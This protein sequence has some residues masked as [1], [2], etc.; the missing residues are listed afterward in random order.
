[1]RCDGAAP[2]WRLPERDSVSA[3]DGWPFPTWMD[4]DG[5]RRRMSDPEWGLTFKLVTDLDTFMRGYLHG[6]DEMPRFPLFRCI[7]S[8]VTF[9]MAMGSAAAANRHGKGYA[10]AI[11]AGS[12]LQIYQAVIRLIAH[13][14]TLRNFRSFPGPPMPKG[15]A[16]PL[17]SDKGARLLFGANAGT[18]TPPK[19]PKLING[20][21][22]ICT[23]AHYFL[24]LHEVAHIFC[25]HV[26]RSAEINRELQ[27]LRPEER[28]QFVRA[29]R[30]P[31]EFLADA[32]S[33][34]FA[35]NYINT[36]VAGRRPPSDSTARAE[37]LEHLVFW[38]F[39]IAVTFLLFETL[40]V[41]E[42][43]RR[44]PTAAERSFYSRNSALTQSDGSP[45]GFTHVSAQEGFTAIGLGYEEALTAW[46]NLGWE[47][48]RSIPQN[49]EEFAQIVNL[50]ANKC[51]RPACVTLR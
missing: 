43:E 44:Y 28:P 10:I 9:R 50:E 16:L 41:S 47:R 12:G 19:D 6:S 48:N 31:L 14:N 23:F 29:H 40:S 7:V 18:V 32:W 39:G 22:A 11:E 25:G 42:D 33:V 20:F 4:M 1:M 8:G 5:A 21:R 37:I 45:I 51:I 27:V 36:V 2:C 30:F 15:V 49:F 38:G 35:T 3:P 24:F 26:E 46:D 13:P 34:L 17:L